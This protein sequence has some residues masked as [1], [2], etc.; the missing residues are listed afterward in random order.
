MRD[1]TFQRCLRDEP[2]PLL[3]KIS[4]SVETLTFAFSPHYIAL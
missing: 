4:C 3:L 2:S 1:A